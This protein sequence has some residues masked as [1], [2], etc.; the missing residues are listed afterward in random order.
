M[1]VEI[2][3]FERFIWLTQKYSVLELLF[4]FLTV[5]AIIY[6]ILEKTGVLGSSDVAHRVN[7]VLA[8]CIAG[9]VTFFTPFG[10]SMI[11]FL[12]KTFTVTF[13]IVFGLL[14]VILFSILL[15]TAK[16]EKEKRGWLIVFTAVALSF[17]TLKSS[18]ILENFQPHVP[19]SLL[20]VIAVL[21][22]VFLI[23][24]ALFQQPE[25]EKKE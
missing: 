20:V 3:A 24:Y 10:I 2:S 4:P 12:S 16:G 22:A 11:D 7:V 18:G 25:E 5:F 14:L 6:A 17:L 9:M 21:G 1:V 23:F 8:L 19:T 13:V 15:G